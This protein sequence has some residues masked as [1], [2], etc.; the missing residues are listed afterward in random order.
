[1]TGFEICNLKSVLFQFL[2]SIVIASVIGCDER[3]G[4]APANA[5]SAL[6]KPAPVFQGVG[7]TIR[8]KV[9]LVGW[10]PPRAAASPVICGDKTH[11]IPDETVVLNGDGGL[12]HVIV[13]LKL[14][15]SSTSVPSDP[16]VLDQ[17]G[18]V[19]KPHVV[20]LRAGQILRIKSSDATLHNVHI[21]SELNPGANFGMMEPGSRDISFKSAERFK[22]KCDVHPWMS[23]WVVV[24][25]HPYFCVTNKSGEFEIG[26]VPPGDYD[27]VAWQERFGEL[28]NTI[29]VKAGEQSDMSFVFRPKSTTSN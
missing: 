13:Y 23:A 8:G 2:A 29:T 19:Y 15:A 5:V 25:D 1:L 6:L 4:P 27:V 10:T 24:I 21:L 12:Q 26:N 7:G 20:G 16:V 28:E 11:Q 18:C 3:I 17:V 9:T 22:I 14:G